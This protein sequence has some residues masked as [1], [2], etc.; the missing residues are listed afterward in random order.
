MASCW[1]SATGSWPRSPHLQQRLGRKVVSAKMLRDFPVHLRLYDILFDG[2]EDVRTMPFDARRAR[3]ETWFAQARP[4]RMDLSTMIPFTSVAEL[5]T[6][7]EGTRAASIEGLMLK[8]ADSPYVPGTAEG[9]VVEVEARP[10][11]PSMP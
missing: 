3:L 2:A 9:P 11:G 7:R 10:A 5:A 1:L 4:A 6:T 8:R